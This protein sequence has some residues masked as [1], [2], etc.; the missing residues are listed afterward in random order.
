MKEE[1]MATETSKQLRIGNSLNPDVSLFM[2]GGILFLE[3]LVKS[4]SAMMKNSSE[5]TQE[6][7]TF[8]HAQLQANI[9]AWQTFS[10]CRNP[11]DLSACQA[12]FTKEAIALYSDEARKLT[13]LLTSVMS[14]TAVPI[15]E[16]AL[17]H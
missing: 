3:N 8:S 4:N 11:S 2:D 9:K 17:K 12:E 7:L 13:N 15:Q 5:L 16:Q 1:A 6:L 10:A 14:N